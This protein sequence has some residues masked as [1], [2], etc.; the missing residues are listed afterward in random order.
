MEIVGCLSRKV[1]FVCIEISVYLYITVYI[2]ICYHCIN[3]TP[4]KIKTVF[5]VSYQFIL[6][7]QNEILYPVDIRLCKPYS[8]S[9]GKGS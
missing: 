1:S 7:L 3:N 2:F 6:E 9:G 4:N 5:P 8:A